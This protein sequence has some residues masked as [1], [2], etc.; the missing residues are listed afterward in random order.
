MAVGRSW[1]GR[2]VAPDP[3][4]SPAGSDERLDADALVLAVGAHVVGLP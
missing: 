1:S 4:T 3:A 2:T